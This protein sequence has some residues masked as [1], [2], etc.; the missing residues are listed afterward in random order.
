MLTAEGFFER[1]RQQHI[2]NIMITTSTTNAA[3]PTIRYSKFTCST[4]DPLAA[5]AIGE[6]D[7]AKEGVTVGW[8]VGCK[9]EG[10]VGLA[11]GAAVLGKNDG[12]LEGSSL[13]LLVGVALGRREGTEEGA[14]L[15]E[16]VGIVG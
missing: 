16:K 4:S 1:R 6:L 5:A 15:G 12:S 14:M 2:H 9:V 3:G 11:V 13:G 8:M 10:L 7:G